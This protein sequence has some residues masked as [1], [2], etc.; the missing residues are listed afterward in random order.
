[1]NYNLNIFQTTDELNSAAAEVIIEI[2]KEAIIA[3]GRF[4]ISLAGGQ[5]PLGLYSLLAK[6][7]WRERID[8]VRTFIFWGDERYV[9]FDSDQNNAHQAQSIFLSRIHIPTTNIHPINVNLQ[10]DEA[11]KD[12]EKDIRTFF[13]DDPWRFDLVLLGLGENGHTASLFPG[14]IVLTEKAEGVRDIYVEEEK[15]YR[16]T[17]TAPLINQARQILFLVSGSKKREIVKNILTLPYQPE[18]FPAQ[19]ISPNDGQLHWFVDQAAA[20]M[21]PVGRG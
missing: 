16:I 11:A 13:G 6:L 1:L 14:T 10:P 4:T 18:K 15:M 8:W 19:L 20:S 12:Y 2:A 17:M 21:L 7:P 9:R 3:R 5:T